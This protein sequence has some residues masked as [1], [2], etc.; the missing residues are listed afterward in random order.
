M[1][2]VYLDSKYNE[3]VLDEDTYEQIA[4]LV[5][6][7]KHCTYNHNSHP[8]T[9]EN[10]CV[11]RNICLQHLLQKQPQLTFLDSPG[12]NADGEHLYRFV[13]KQGVVYTSTEDHS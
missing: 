3:F 8:Y 1:K 2:S 9:Q 13:D 7:A 4:A 6:G 10:P 11:G 5:Q 12:T